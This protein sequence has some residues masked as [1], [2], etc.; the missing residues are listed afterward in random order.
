MPKLISR[1]PSRS[2]WCQLITWYFYS[3][4]S[5]F[6]Q[7]F[8]MA[9]QHP[10]VNVNFLQ[11]LQSFFLDSCIC[12]SPTKWRDITYIIRYIVWPLN[13]YFLHYYL[14]NF[15]WIVPLNFSGQYWLQK[16]HP[17]NGHH[18]FHGFFLQLD[19]GRTS[20]CFFQQI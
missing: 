12:S 18:R 8:P 4:W 17:T 10:N 11:C 14:I 13:I 15:R 5:S 1:E 6:F 20:V 7:S 9:D 3:T 19:N 16:C 2:P